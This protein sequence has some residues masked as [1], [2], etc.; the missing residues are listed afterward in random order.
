MHDR[1]RGRVSRPSAERPACHLT[2]RLHSNLPRTPDL[3]R[4]VAVTCK[5]RPCRRPRYSWAQTSSAKVGRDDRVRVYS[6]LN[7]S[8]TIAPTSCTGAAG[9]L[10][11]VSSQDRQRGMAKKRQPVATA[12]PAPGPAKTRPST[13]SAHQSQSDPSDP[14]VSE[15]KT[16]KKGQEHL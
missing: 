2:C 16:A 7:H 14:K 12:A 10:R 1:S 13:S 4:R 5:R 15:K 8:T 11:V 6:I 3:D 9:N